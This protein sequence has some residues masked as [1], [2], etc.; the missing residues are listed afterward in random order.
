VNFRLATRTA[1]SR[2]RRLLVG[3]LTASS[4][5]LIRI[6]AGR[7]GKTQHADILPNR[8]AAAWSFAVVNEPDVRSQL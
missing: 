1:L 7:F 4:G 5:P 6:E 8:A 3:V 2:D